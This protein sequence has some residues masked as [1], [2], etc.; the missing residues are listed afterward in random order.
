MDPANSIQV[1]QQQQALVFQKLAIEKLFQLNG[2]S[3]ILSLNSFQDLIQQTDRDNVA[4][5]AAAIASGS[6]S[7]SGNQSGSQWPPLI[8]NQ[9]SNLTNQTTDYHQRTF[10][11]SFIEHYQ[12][13]QLISTAIHQYQQQQQQQLINRQ[14]S[15]QSESNNLDIDENLDNQEDSVICVDV[16]DD[17]SIQ[18]QETKLDHQL[19]T[20]IKIA[21]QASSSN[22]TNKVLPTTTTTQLQATIEHQLPKLR[23][24]VCDS[25]LISTLPRSQIGQQL[26]CTSSGSKITTNNGSTQEHRINSKKMLAVRPETNSNTDCPVVCLEGGKDDLNRADGDGLAGTGNTNTKHRRCRTNFTV[27][28]LKE[29]ERL[30]DETHYPDAFMREDISNRLNL[31]ENRVQVWFQNRRAKCRKEE[32]RASYCGNSSFNDELAYLRS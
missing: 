13:N 16:E 18:Q 11:E 22:C 30:F 1:S 7:S 26:S 9:Y 15:G 2:T 28:Q 24:R 29:L 19:E 5:S 23:V 14:S 17:S 4:A 3:N 21:P 6:N 27:E 31:S 25:K 20:Q 8:T 10:I 12:R 32:A